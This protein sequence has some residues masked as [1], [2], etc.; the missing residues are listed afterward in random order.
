MYVYVCMYECMCVFQFTLAV[1]MTIAS[2]GLFLL[3]HIS[4]RVLLIFLSLFFWGFG[5]AFVVGGVLAFGLVCIALAIVAP[6][7]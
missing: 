6:I 3:H 2:S 5:L 4:G 7:D 1:A